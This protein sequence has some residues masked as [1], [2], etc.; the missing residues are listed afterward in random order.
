MDEPEPESI[1]RE[2]NKSCWTIGYTGQS[3]ERLKAHMRNMNVFDVKT[4][5]RQGRHRQ[6]DRLR[7]RRRLLRPAVAV[8]RHAGAQ[9]PGL[10]EPVRHHPST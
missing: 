4:L 5:Q 2:I 3:P 10:A 1:L 8:L 9:A 6:G 7:P